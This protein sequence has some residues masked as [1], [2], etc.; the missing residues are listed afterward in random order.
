MA[1]STAKSKKTAE[2][3]GLKP[4]SKHSLYFYQ[5]GVPHQNKHAA[6]AA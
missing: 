1:P 4:S 3:M 5:D 2:T 6:A